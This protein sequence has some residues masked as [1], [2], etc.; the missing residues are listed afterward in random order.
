[1]YRLS[2]PTLVMAEVVLYIGYDYNYIGGE[3]PKRGNI[4][5]ECGAGINNFFVLS[6]TH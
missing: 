5:D 3:R 2:T 6:F 1:M 4:Q